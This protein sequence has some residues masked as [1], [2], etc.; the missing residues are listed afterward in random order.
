MASMLN[1]EKV[2]QGGLAI[3]I[4]AHTAQWLLDCHLSISSINLIL[5]HEDEDDDGDA[6]GQAVAGDGVPIDGNLVACEKS[7]DGDDPEYVEDCA[8]DDGADAEVTLCDERSDDVGEELRRA[9]SWNE[10]HKFWSDLYPD[11]RS[12]L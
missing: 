4:W 10:P 3:W 2:F 11:Q 8:A 1:W 6:V 12:T 5:Q 9:C 7:T